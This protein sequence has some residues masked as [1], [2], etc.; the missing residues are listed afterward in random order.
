[1][2]EQ[3]SIFAK[4]GG[5]HRVRLPRKSALAA[6]PDNNVAVQREAVSARPAAVDDND[7][8]G[9]HADHL[10]WRERACQFGER[11]EMP[12]PPGAVTRAQIRIEGSVAGG[13]WHA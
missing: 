8:I 4:D 3:N 1:M 9:R 10:R 5:F 2:A 11:I 12:Q 13:E 6:R 7:I